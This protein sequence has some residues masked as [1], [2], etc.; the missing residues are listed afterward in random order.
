MNIVNRLP[1]DNFFRRSFVCSQLDLPLDDRLRA[2]GGRDGHWASRHGV[3]GMVHP[4]AGPGLHRDRA[5]RSPSGSH[6]SR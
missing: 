2:D 5:R 4:S 3:A 6:T 1:A